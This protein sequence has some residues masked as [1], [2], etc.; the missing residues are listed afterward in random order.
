MLRTITGM[1]TAR[2]LRARRRR[3]VRVAAATSHS[4]D[5][6]VPR[7]KGQTM[8]QSQA[9]TAGPH[10]ELLTLNEVAEILRTPPATLR[11]WRHLGTGPDSFRL[12]RR[13]MYRRDDLDHWVTTRHDVEAAHR[14]GARRDQG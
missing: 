9:P 2:I 12:G 13:V 14:Q 3:L 4:G 5:Y 1:D 10:T 6:T 8:D 7:S 11:Y